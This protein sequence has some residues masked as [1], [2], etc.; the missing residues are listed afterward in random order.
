MPSPASIE[1]IRRLVSHDT[2][3][4]LSNFGLI[5][6]VRDYLKRFG[7]ESE[8][9]HDETGLK[10]NLYATIGPTHKAGICLSGHTDVVP[11]DG[12]EWL[13]DPF[14]LEE[15]DG[16]LY[17][18]GTCDMKSYLAVA[19]AQVPKMVAADLKT[20]IHLALSYDEEVGCIGVRRL[21]DML[22]AAEVKPAMVIVGEPTS[23]EVVTAHKGKRSFRCH[24]TGK[25]AHSSLAPHGVNAVEFAA[26]AIAKLRQKA[27]KFQ[28]EGPFDKEFD[29]AHTTAHVGIISGGTA[30]NIVPEI[31]VFDYEFRYLPGEDAIALQN[32]FEQ[33]V[34][35]SLEPK[36]HKIDPD[37]GFRFE[38]RSEFPPLETPADA[39][40]VKF[41][42]N[43]V[44]GGPLKKVAYGTEGGLF[45]KTA[46][47]PT[48][49]CGPGSIDQAHKPDEFVTLDQVDRCEKFIQRLI[50]YAAAN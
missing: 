2:T 38:T 4:R 49:I 8:L 42:Q 7:I 6:E 29:V 17:G 9:V 5:E 1:M 48:I 27:E 41:G 18:R 35:D 33:F 26:L 24:V 12:Q 11:V 16:K 34:K 20:P 39:E 50:E 13:S 45:Q 15:Q 47:V 21:I 10:A 25:A 30:L 19:L 31:C 23:M 43:L 14:R 44:G 32:E 46:G 36:M 40:V 37:T 22:N 3:S 28:S